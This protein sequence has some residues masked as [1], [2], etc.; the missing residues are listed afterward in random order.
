[1]RKEYQIKEQVWIHN[2]ET[3]L[4]EGRVVEVFDLEHLNEG[5]VSNDELYVIEIQTGIEPVYEVRSWDQISPDS[6]GP[7]N[8]YRNQEVRRAARYFRKVGIQ[9][10]ESATTEPIVELLPKEKP[11]RKYYRSSK[12]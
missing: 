5:C 4:V 1:M 6:K 10:P 11:K 12:K 8:L 2:G 3:S 9:I 7:I